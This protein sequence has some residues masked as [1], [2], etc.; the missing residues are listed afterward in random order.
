MPAGGQLDVETFALPQVPAELA[1]DLTAGSYVAM[2]VADTGTGMAPDVQARAFEPFFTTKELGKGTG[3]GLSQVYGF[4]RQSGGTIRIR[5]EVGE[6]TRVSIYLPRAEAM[7][8]QPAE[9]IASASPPRDRQ[10]ATILVADD[11]ENVRE[12]VVAMLEEL[13]Y[14]VIAAAD[15]QSA[16][17]VIQRGEAFDLLVA[18]VVMPGLSGVEVAQRARASGRPLRVLFATGYADVAV[19][20][21]GL[22][23]EDMIRKPYRMTE[24]AE[25]VEQAL[26]TPMR[27][28]GDRPGSRPHPDR[29]HPVPP[30]RTDPRIADGVAKQAKAARKVTSD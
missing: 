20:R 14:R 9:P 25:R 7:P 21:E 29:A 13:G 19:Y 10:R 15:G 23:G 24:L 3:L 11:D 1:D 30:G 8:V 16:L 2:V 22:E 6:G 4:V 18:D 28:V 26:L 12:L 17:E 5:S 27:P